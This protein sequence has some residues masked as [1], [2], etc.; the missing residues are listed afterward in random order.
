MFLF[1]KTRWKP[2]RSSVFPEADLH[3]AVKAGDEL[4]SDCGVFTINVSDV[5]SPT[6]E[7]SHGGDVGSG[8]DKENY[9]LFALRKVPLRLSCGAFIVQ[10]M[11]AT[12]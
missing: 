7:R 1:Q 9:L 4:F 2:K 6:G 10:L 11:Q 8:H 3:N 12:A 5:F